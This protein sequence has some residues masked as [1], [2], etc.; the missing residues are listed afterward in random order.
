MYCA[1][2]VALTAINLQPYF[3]IDIEVVTICISKSRDL[4]HSPALYTY[5]M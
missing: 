3:S 4:D 1:L 2:M 5:K